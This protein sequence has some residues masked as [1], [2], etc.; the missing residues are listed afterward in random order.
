M[1]TH[2]LI[3][4]KTH[5]ISAFGNTLQSI[6]LMTQKQKVLATSPCV[7]VWNVP[8]TNVLYVAL[9][10]NCWKMYQHHDEQVFSVD[11]RPNTMTCLLPLT[12]KIVLGGGSDKALYIWKRDKLLGT[13]HFHTRAI[14][15][16]ASNSSD[17]FA[18]CDVEMNIFLWNS[19][20]YT[21]WRRFIMNDM[22]VARPLILF[23]DDM[24][25][26]L[27]CD[28]RS[29]TLKAWNLCDVSFTQT[30]NAIEF[31]NLGCELSTLTKKTT[32]QGESVQFTDQRGKMFS[33]NI[34]NGVG[35][36]DV[37]APL[38]KVVNSDAL[39]HFLTT[40]KHCI[41]KHTDGSVK[42]GRKLTLTRNEEEGGKVY[43]PWSST[44]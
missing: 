1:Q 12:P 27:A 42:V 37:G 35:Q 25:H 39:L 34:I 9:F 26:M 29:G 2:S 18:T 41:S 5:A 14:V 38:R 4:L 17:Y 15:E 32:T 13:R 10:A 3:A 24:R 16:I 30:D 28:L 31:P 44:I 21:V 7:G 43:C 23:S 8:C 36:L 40:D 20:D 11:I 33:M 19:L 22:R 6:H